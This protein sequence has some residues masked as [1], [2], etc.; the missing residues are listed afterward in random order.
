MAASILVVEDEPAIQELI[1]VNLAREGHAVR[2]ALSAAEAYQAAAAVARPPCCQSLTIHVNRS[3]GNTF[4][5]ASGC[6]EC[7]APG[8][9][10]RRN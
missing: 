5:H 6:V 8:S 3:C 1:S 9:D 4:R 10:L 7:P 2:R